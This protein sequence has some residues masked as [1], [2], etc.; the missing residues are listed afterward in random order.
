MP[1]KPPRPP[2]FTETMQIGIVVPDLDAA[3]RHFEEDYGIGPWSHFELDT[4]EGMDGAVSAKDVLLDGKPGHYHCRS[5]SAMVGSVQWELTEPLDD[6]SLFAEFLRRTG[7]GVHH[8]AVQTP[9]YAQTLAAEKAAGR[10]LPLNGTFAGIPVS[11]LGTSGT[12]GTLIEVFDFKGDP[13][14]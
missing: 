8:I 13:R 6:T 9:D 10:I 2:V 12:I 4:S 11:Y 3:I 7:G 5:A 14:G 1:E